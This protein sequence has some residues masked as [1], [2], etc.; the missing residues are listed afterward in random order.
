MAIAV[1]QQTSGDRFCINFSSADASGTEVLKAA[2]TT[3]ARYWIDKIA[4][5][6]G[7]DITVTIKDGS[8][9][10]IGPLTINDSSFVYEF[11]VAKQCTVN[12]ALNLLAGDGAVAGIIEGHAI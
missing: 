5:T 2:S 6:T 1:A 9:V 4:I 3:G 11:T 10:I 8:T 7:A 12:T